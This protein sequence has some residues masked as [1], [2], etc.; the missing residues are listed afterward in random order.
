VL[1]D[2]GLVRVRKEEEEEEEGAN[3]EVEERGRVE[4]R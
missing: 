3:E 4:E 2:A 1:P